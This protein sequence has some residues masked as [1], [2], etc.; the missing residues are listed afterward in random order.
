[1]EHVSI[2][3]LPVTEMPQ[4]CIQIGQWL[5]ISRGWIQIKSVVNNY[6][7]AAAT[8]AYKQNGVAAYSKPKVF[9]TL[10]SA[11]KPCLN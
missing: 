7:K 2:F 9:T 6:V 5:S 1:M 8:E 11:V 4:A 10:S 3:K